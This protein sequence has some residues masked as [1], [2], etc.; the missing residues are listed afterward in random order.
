LGFHDD[1]IKAEQQQR[2][3]ADAEIKKRQLEDMR[4]SQRASESKLREWFDSV[5]MSPHPQFTSMDPK[6]ESYSLSD[7]LA[8]H[9]VID[10]RWSVDGYKYSARWSDGVL[11]VAI[12]I[13]GREFTVRDRDSIGRV[14]F[15]NR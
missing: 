11:S 2:E 4:N 6:W 9:W 14:L 3:K 1:L 12:H 15:E 10:M 5:G 13:R 7:E 8:Y